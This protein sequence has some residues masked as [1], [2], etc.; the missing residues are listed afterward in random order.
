MLDDGDALKL[1]MI[2]TRKE[3]NYSINVKKTSNES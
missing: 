2:P 1:V 3:R